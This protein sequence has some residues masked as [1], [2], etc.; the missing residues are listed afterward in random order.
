MNT[1]ITAAIQFI[2]LTD[3]KTAYREIDEIISIIQSME[4]NYTVCPFETV[5]EG[6]LE[7]I[8]KVITAINE[9]SKTLSCEQFILNV[10]FHINKNQNLSLE[11]N[12]KKYSK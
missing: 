6:T 3:P 5:I 1:Q 9:K 4:L 10:K 2:P 7:N 8:L 11:T 12:I